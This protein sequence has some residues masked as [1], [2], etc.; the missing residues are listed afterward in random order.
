MTPEELNTF[1]KM[2]PGL[3]LGA[4]VTGLVAYLFIRFYLS[5]YL[6]EKAKNNATKED[7]A[8][9]TRLVEDV[10]TP[11]LASL[12]DLK[13]KHQLRMAAIDAR[14]QAHQEAFTLWRELLRVVYTDEISK[15]VVKCQT[16]WE[17]NCVYLEPKVRSSFVES[18]SAAS[19]HRQLVQ[20]RSDEQVI[21]SNWETVIGF[22]DILFEAVALPK[23]TDGEVEALEINASQGFPKA[24]R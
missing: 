5:V 22:P 12:E 11:Y 19:I 8:G 23:L 2:I 20:G 9:L 3:G 10:R 17:G 18:Y 7:I 1:Y 24:P 4:I 16:W 15:A 6:G 14:L 21:R 13:G